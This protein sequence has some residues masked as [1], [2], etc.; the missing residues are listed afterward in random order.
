MENFNNKFRNKT[1]RNAEWKLEKALTPIE[2]TKR[3]D[4]LV[5]LN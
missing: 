5:K 3:A 2:Y 4:E 1:L